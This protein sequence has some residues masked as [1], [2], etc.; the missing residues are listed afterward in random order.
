MDFFE[1][2][3]WIYEYLGLYNY[4]W[5]KVY[6]SPSDGLDFAVCI[7]PLFSDDFKCT[8]MTNWIWNPSVDQKPPEFCQSGKSNLDF[9][10]VT[11]D[12][13]ELSPWIPMVSFSSFSLI[14]LWSLLCFCAL[15]HPIHRT[16]PLYWFSQEIY[17]EHFESLVKAHIAEHNFSPSWS[18]SPPPHPLT[19]SW[20]IC[21]QV[22]K[23]QLE[24]DMEQWTSSNWERSMLRLHIVIL[25]I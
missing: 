1:T 16:E 11:C 21:M 8:S 25:L 18:L 10:C 12:G 2:Y 7:F 6:G 15:W 20:E 5:Y 14:S 17:T 22:K 23:Q 19:C 4:I 13:I 9:S 24:P 3:L